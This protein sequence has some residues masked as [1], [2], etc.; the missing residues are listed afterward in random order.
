MASFDHTKEKTAGKMADLVMEYVSQ[1]IARDYLE[2]YERTMNE[3]RYEFVP[4]EF[5]EKIYKTITKLIR[6][7]TRYKLKILRNIAG[8][9]IAFLCILCVAFTIFVM[10]NSPLRHAVFD[11]IGSF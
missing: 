10:L 11:I 3:E 6:K 5:D 1:F 2:A 7:K 9:V 4:S 8:A